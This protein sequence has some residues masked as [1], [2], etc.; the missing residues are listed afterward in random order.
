MTVLFANFRRL[1]SMSRE[2]V[3]AAFAPVSTHTHR[4]GAGRKFADIY[5]LEKGENTTF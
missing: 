3:M 5:F 4:A 1:S 2:G